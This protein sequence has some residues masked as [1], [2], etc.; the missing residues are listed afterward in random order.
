MTR[1]ETFLLE[2]TQILLALVGSSAT[3]YL[4]LD[5]LNGGA[6]EL[7]LLN[8]PYWIPSVAVALTG[9][10]FIAI[11]IR[12]RTYKWALLGGFLA[13]FLTFG[14][15]LLYAIGGAIVLGAP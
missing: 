3:V 2:G 10:P 1:G 6:P 11:S 4:S 9:I 7:P 14:F 15:L 13:G 8:A 5:M 12:F